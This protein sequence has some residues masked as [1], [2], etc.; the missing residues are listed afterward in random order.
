MVGGRAVGV[1]RHQRCQ[2]SWQGFKDLIINPTKY[3]V[4]LGGFNVECAKSVLE[5]HGIAYYA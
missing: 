3:M 2:K 5:R 1:R 4:T